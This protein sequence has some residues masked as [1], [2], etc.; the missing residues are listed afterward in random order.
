L[1]MDERRGRNYNFI[2]IFLQVLDDRTNVS[3]T[4]FIYMDPTVLSS[5]YTELSCHKSKMAV[6]YSAPPLPPIRLT[7][8]S[9]IL[10]SMRK[11]K[12]LKQE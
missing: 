11:L 5:R 10:C 8:T 4:M 9:F 2:F 3:W 1:N 7:L 12:F 6:L